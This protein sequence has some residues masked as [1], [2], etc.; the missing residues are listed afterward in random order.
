LTDSG[1]TDFCEFFPG[2]ILVA[3]PVLMERRGFDVNLD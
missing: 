1:V 3:A 2:L